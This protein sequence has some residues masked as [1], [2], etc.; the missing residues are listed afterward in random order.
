MPLS[1]A[2]QAEY[3]REYRK[4]SVIPK[5]PSVIPNWVAQ[6]NRYLA[7]HLRVCPD[8]NPVIPAD[9]FDHCPY[10]NPLLRPSVIPTGWTVS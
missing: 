3:M 1:K 8:D 2:K 4:R 10:I 6:P 7:A 5:S 9:H